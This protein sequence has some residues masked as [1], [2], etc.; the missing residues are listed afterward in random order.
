MLLPFALI[1]EPIP[2][3]LHAKPTDVVVFGEISAN[4]LVCGRLSPKQIVYLLEGQPQGVNLL[5]E[6]LQVSRQQRDI[7]LLFSRKLILFHKYLHIFW[8]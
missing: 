5:I 3:I 1:V 8:V 6:L 4:S 7:D 2:F